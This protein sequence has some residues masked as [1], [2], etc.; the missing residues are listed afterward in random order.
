MNDRRSRREK[1]ALRT[2]ILKKENAPGEKVPVLLADGLL[3]SK[4][5]N[6]KF[7]Q[8]K[9]KE[10]LGESEALEEMPRG[11]LCRKD[12]FKGKKRCKPRTS[13]LR[14]PLF[15]KSTQKREEPHPLDS[16]PY[17]R[18]PPFQES[19][20]KGRDAQRNP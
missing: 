10:L 16:L 1:G 15:G 19:A 5:K 8:L 14:T 11:H 7:E 12:S 18:G 4:T 2:K 6:R 20:D 9:G 13:N 3:F 17:K